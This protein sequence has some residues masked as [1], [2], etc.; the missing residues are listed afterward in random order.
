MF[1]VYKLTRSDGKIYIG[2][3]NKYRL[4]IRLKEHRHSKRFKG[5]SFEHEI[6]NE[7][8]DLIE[9]YKLE[10]ENI[11]KFD[12][13]KNGLNSTPDG[14]GKSRSPKFTTLGCKFSDESRKKMSLAKKGKPIPWFKDIKISPE[15]RLKMS[16]DQKGKQ[17]FTKLTKEN[18][19]NIKN[20]FVQGNFD[21][22]TVGMKCKN[23]K[24]MSGVQSYALQ[25]APLYNVTLQCIKKV[26][27]GET[28]NGQSLQT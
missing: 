13:Y 4:K 14:T 20:E 15:T 26:L 25:K 6:I 10:K 28:W 17:S 11:Q 3:T 16:L 18:V 22:S 23:G 12:S 21:K 19:I 24:L 5:F 9:L 8:M 1:Y 2:T 7:T 27:K